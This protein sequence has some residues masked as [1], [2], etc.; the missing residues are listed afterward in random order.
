MENIKHYL[1]YAILIIL[2]AATLIGIGAYLINDI[3]DM[4]LRKST[5]TRTSFDYHIAAPNSAQVQEIKASSAVKSVFPYYAYSNAFS[6]SKDVMLLFSDEMSSSGISL[7]TE[8]TLI[9]GEYDENGAMLDLTAAEALDVKVGD[10]I[11]FNLLGVSFTKTVSAI[12]LPSEL[13]IMK[14]GIVLVDFSADIAAVNTPAAYSGAF[15][16]AEDRDAVFSLLSDYAGEGNVTLTYEG[17]I[18][19]YCGSKMPNQ[20][21]E[22]YDAAC[23]AK[24][25]EYR[26]ERLASARKDGGQVVDKLEA[27]SLIKEQILTTEQKLSNLRMLTMLAVFAV[28]TVVMILFTVTNAENDK[29]RRDEGLASSQMLLSYVLTTVV[30]SVLTFGA[31]IGILAMIASGTYFVSDCLGM[32]F[33]ISFPILL[34]IIPVFAAAVIYVKRLYAN[35]IRA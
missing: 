4:E 20:S 33:L 29:L 13:A 12:Y 26:E 34:G 8:A 28:F 1:K 14:Q 19:K 22:E 3:S 18:E 6:N 35:N 17:Y 11:R 7:L 27:Y 24:Y 30:S 16:E 32:A 2:L 9:N 15:I 23:A 31:A 25:A 5:Y 21:D 10:T